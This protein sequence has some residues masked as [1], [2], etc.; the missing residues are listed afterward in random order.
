MEGVKGLREAFNQT[1]EPLFT[2]TMALLDYDRANQK[3]WQILTF[4]GTDAEGKPFQ[5]KSQDL[6]PGADMATACR[7]TAQRL[8][9]LRKATS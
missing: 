4:R 3:E 1:S 7:E 5:I 9:D 6:G 2:C 8:I